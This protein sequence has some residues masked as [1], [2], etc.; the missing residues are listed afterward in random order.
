MVR[1][2]QAALSILSYKL[3]WSFNATHSLHPWKKYDGQI[4]SLFHCRESLRE[5]VC[6]LLDR[7]ELLNQLDP[8]L[9]VQFSC[10]EDI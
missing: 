9:T 10:N 6:A 7:L 2:N 5:M 3:G 4:M 8:A 1:H